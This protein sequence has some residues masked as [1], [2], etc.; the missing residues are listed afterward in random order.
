MNWN[1]FF[2]ILTFAYILYFS[3][4]IL[5]DVCR[6]PRADIAEPDGERLIFEQEEQPKLVGHGQG[7]SQAVT[8]KDRSDAVSSGPL[9]GTGGVSLKEL[10]SLAQSDLIKFTGVISY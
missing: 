10:F 9:H 1:Q 3:L 5:F 6:N 2:I 8:P 7:A 4:N